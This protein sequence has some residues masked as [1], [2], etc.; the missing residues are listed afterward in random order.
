M[1]SI[2]TRYVGLGYITGADK[3]DTLEAFDLG[4]FDSLA[5]QQCLEGMN[6]ERE[7]LNILL[8]IADAGAD[9]VKDISAR[10]GK[11]LRVANLTTAQ[12]KSVRAEMNEELADQREISVEAAAAIMTPVVDKCA[13]NN[14]LNVAGN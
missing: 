12:L 9:E 4:I 1:D 10:A 3:T 8:A 2:L 14:R 5:I 7:A 11:T 6:G 13:L